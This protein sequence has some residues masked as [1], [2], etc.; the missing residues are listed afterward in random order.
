M[1]LFIRATRKQ[2]KGVTNEPHQIPRTISPST[3]ESSGQNDR[4][5]GYAGGFARLDAQ[6]CHEETIEYGT[7]K[8]Q[9]N[10]DANLEIEI[11][12][13]SSVTYRGEDSNEE[14]L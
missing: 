1:P 6:R 13:K 2:N 8:D 11:G 7:S 4:G 5:I 9:Q 3:F 12:K 14:A 10:S